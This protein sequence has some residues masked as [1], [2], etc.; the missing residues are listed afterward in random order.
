MNRQFDFFQ[1]IKKTFLF[2]HQWIQA[3][4]NKDR[5]FNAG[6]PSVDVKI[7]DCGNEEKFKSIC[8]IFY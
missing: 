1:W 8:I 4:V 2:R 7:Q 6:I 3:G 5:Q